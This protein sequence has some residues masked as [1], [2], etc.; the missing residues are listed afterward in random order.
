MWPIFAIFLN[1][2]LFVFMMVHNGR[3]KKLPKHVSKLPLTSSLLQSEPTALS[4]EP[5][6][7]KKGDLVK[8]NI[9][10]QA[11]L[12]SENN[13]TSIGVV[14][15]DARSYFM[16]FDSSS[17]TYWVYDLFVGNELVICVPQN[18]MVRIKKNVNE[19]NSQ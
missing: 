13:S 7:F 1:L 16:G 6:R 19:E 12:I 14:I 10:G 8:L 5:P 3:S 11:M 9:F 4:L 17:I 15:S 18:F 2:F